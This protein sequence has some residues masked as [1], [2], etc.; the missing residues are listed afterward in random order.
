M[1]FNYAIGAS[2]VALLLATA[3]S[4]SNTA[5]GTVSA[6]QSGVDVDVSYSDRSNFVSKMKGE[7]DDVNNEIRRVSENA[8]K[9]TNSPESQARLESL[10][11]KATNLN[12]QID[13]VQSA[14]ESTWADIKASSQKAYDQAKDSLRNAKDWTAQKLHEAGDKLN[15]K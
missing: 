2:V 11:E 4:K 15:S 8:A 7:L 10:K 13:K 3:C 1:K 6:N 12:I 9:S 5:Q 14:T